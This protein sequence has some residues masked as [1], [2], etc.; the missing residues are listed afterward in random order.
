MRL[1][2]QLE[3]GTEVGQ[4]GWPGI[5]IAQPSGPP[6]LAPSPLVGVEGKAG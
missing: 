6:A 4:V 1:S 5:L 2:F 3:K